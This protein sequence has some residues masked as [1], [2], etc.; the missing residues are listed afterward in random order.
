MAK[1]LDLYVSGD[2]ISQHRKFECA[3]KA[4]DKEVKKMRKNP[5][6]ERSDIDI[7]F[8]DESIYAYDGDNN[9]VYD[10]TYRLK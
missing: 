2:C 7:M 9:E 1:L 10:Y 5:I 6:D 8:E 3:K 4:F